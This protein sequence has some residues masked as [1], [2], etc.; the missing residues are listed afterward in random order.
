MMIV[1]ILN[2]FIFNYHLS[3]SKLNFNFL[4]LRFKVFNKPQ[5][6]LM[7]K[8]SEFF[9]KAFLCGLWS[10]ILCKVFK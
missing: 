1:K 6:K 2:Y 8:L 5:I 4:D 10:V 9:V 3:Q 7:L